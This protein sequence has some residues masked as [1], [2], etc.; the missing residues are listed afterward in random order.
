MRLGTDE[1]HA[2]SMIRKRV[3]VATG[4]LDVLADV[5]EIIWI[6]LQRILGVWVYES[7]AIKNLSL[8]YQISELEVFREKVE[9]FA[10]VSLW[11][12]TLTLNL[13][14][15]FLSSAGV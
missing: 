2:L 14:S 12:K 6:E 9:I 11:E 7:D 3:R 13:T 8:Q 5:K 4:D 1:F 15:T 10:K